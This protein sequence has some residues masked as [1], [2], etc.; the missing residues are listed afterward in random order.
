MEDGIHTVPLDITLSPWSESSKCIFYETP[1][2][3]LAL[4]YPFQFT[5]KGN[6]FYNVEQFILYSKLLHHGEKSKAKESLVSSSLFQ[7]RKMCALLKTHHTWYITLDEILKWS[8]QEKLTKCL[9]FQQS[10]NTLKY[11][12]ILYANKDKY[13]GTGLS[14]KL[15][16]I[17][18]DKNLPGN[19]KLGEFL[20]ELKRT[21]QNLSVT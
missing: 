13:M 6:K 2:D 11:N 18:K 16:E 19:N 4:S 21:Q 14:L 3:P 9:P 12:N 10:L 20:Q 1:L 8:L 5:Y 17:T 7:S 15:T